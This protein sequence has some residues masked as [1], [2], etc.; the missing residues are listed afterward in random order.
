MNMGLSEVLEKNKWWWH[1]L[2]VCILMFFPFLLNF[3]FLFK[4]LLH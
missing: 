1:Y 2:H 3:Y 4:F